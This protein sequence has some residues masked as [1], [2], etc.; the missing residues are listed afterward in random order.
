M[1]MMLERRPVRE[2][3][4]SPRRAL[5]VLQQFSAETGEIGGDIHVVVLRSDG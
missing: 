2:Q 4:G 1:P 5:G 3:R